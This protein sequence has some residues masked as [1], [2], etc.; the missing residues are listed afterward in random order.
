MR[1]HQLAITTMMAFV[2]SLAMSA[3]AFAADISGWFDDTYNYETN[4]R[5]LVVVKDSND[6]DTRTP[7][8]LAA[9]K[10]R[11]YLL[12]DKWTVTLPEQ[13]NGVAVPTE[14]EE[15]LDPETNLSELL[16]HA[17]LVALVD[18][19]HYHEYVKHIEAQTVIKP[20]KEEVPVYDKDGKKIGTRERYRHVAEVT[21]AH[22][23]TV[24]EMDA[25]VT[26]I[27]MATK[28]ILGRFTYS[29]KTYDGQTAIYA[30]FGDEYRHAYKMAWKR[31][32]KQ[33]KQNKKA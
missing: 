30:N 17:E 13:L 9:V 23:V 27:D 4:P 16:P 7:V 25:E 11:Q 5:F 15:Y 18:L 22:D 24:R 14:E 1:R 28:R 2:L 3:L 33:N 20:V 21:P 26:T 32:V 8:N 29:T 6:S 31:S 19:T 12:K 10:V